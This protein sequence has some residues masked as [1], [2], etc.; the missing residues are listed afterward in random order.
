MFQRE[1]ALGMALHAAMAS[2]ASLRGAL[3]VIGEETPET[4]ELIVL[5]TRYTE[6]D[7]D[8][9]PRVLFGQAVE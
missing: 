5:L 3:K 9:R 2:L 6:R 1:I 4:S 8:H 7:R